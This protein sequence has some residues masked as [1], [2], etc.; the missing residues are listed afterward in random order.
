MRLLKINLK[1][2]SLR[3]VVSARRFLVLLIWIVFKTP[4]C[5]RLAFPSL[6]AQRSKKFSHIVN[7]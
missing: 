3:K 1:R 7:I 5:T 2:A 6:S 4:V